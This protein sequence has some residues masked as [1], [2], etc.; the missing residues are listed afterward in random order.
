MFELAGPA[1][2]VRLGGLASRKA[3]LPAGPAQTS[4]HSIYIYIFP[5]LG[6]PSRVVTFPLVVRL[7]DRFFQKWGLVGKGCPKDA[8][9]ANQKRDQSKTFQTIQSENKSIKN[10]SKHANRKVNENN[11]KKTHRVIRQVQRFLSKE[12][13]V[14]RGCLK[15]APVAKQKRNHLRQSG[16]IEVEKK[17]VKIIST[18][19]NRKEIN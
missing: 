15:D 3:R 8:P 4:C 5:K 7:V 10:T 1:G 6:L 11:P 13:T 12:G 9:V 19:P 17:S 18:I 16:N 2:P 14:G